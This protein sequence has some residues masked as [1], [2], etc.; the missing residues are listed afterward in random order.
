MNE[1]YKLTGRVAYPKDITLISI[2]LE[3]IDNVNAIAIPRFNVFGRWFSD[4]VDGNARSQKRQLKEQKEYSKEELSKFY[5]EDK[6]FREK[7]E[8]FE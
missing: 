4:I 3:D 5:Y 1:K 2:K 8:E 7:E 6:N